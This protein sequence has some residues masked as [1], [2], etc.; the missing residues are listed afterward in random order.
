[1]TSRRT[2]VSRAA[3]VI[4]VFGASACADPELSEQTFYSQRIAPILQEN[5]VRGTAD[6]LCHTE[7][8]QKPC[9]ALCNPDLSS[10]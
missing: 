3:V 5:C 9:E 1:M 6:G 10:F 4:V 2:R 7:S 8:E